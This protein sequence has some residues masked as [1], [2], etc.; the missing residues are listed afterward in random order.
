MPSKSENETLSTIDKTTSQTSSNTNT[1]KKGINPQPDASG[2]KLEPKTSTKDVIDTK[3]S[4]NL[5][6]RPAF[7]P[8]CVCV[9]IHRI[10]LD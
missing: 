6:V 10:N 2:I 5:S 7:L 8:V 3:K 1:T 9:Y 4:T